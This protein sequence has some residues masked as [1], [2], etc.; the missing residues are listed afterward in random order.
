MP[1]CMPES[2]EYIPPQKR[3]NREANTPLPRK[4]TVSLVKKTNVFVNLSTGIKSVTEASNATAVITREKL[5]LNLTETELAKVKADKQAMNII[6]LGL[7]ND[8]YSSVDSDSCSSAFAMWKAIERK[9]QGKKVGLQEKEVTLLWE[10]E[11]FTSMAEESI[12]SY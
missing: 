7:T 2:Q 3:N 8:I 11:K 9:L 5:D 4:E 6:L 1:G 10:Y 12:A